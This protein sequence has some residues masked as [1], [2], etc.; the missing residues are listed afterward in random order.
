[1]TDE[2]NEKEELLKYFVYVLVDPLNYKIFYVGRGQN[3][4][5]DQHKAGEEKQKEK[6][7]F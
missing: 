6:K 3:M 5:P 4:R 1:M 2:K 7:I